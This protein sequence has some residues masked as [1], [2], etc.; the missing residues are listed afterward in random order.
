M[1]YNYGA[2]QP[3]AT[4][5][6]PAPKYR[7]YRSNQ[8]ASASRIDHSWLRN[9]VE[10]AFERMS[11]SGTWGQGESWPNVHILHKYGI[12]RYGYLVHGT[13]LPKVCE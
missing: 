3:P 6:F 8:A 2:N 9:S 13:V 1:C 12:E 5:A 10:C 7:N 11:Q 4:M